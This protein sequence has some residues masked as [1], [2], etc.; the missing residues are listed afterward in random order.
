MYTHKQCI[1]LYLTNDSNFLV[2]I[3]ISWQISSY[4]STLF[5]LQPEI[6]IWTYSF[7]PFMNT[8]F[9]ILFLFWFHCVLVLLFWWETHGNAETQTNLVLNG[10]FFCVSLKFLGEPFIFQTTVKTYYNLCFNLVKFHQCLKILLTC[11]LRGGGSP[12]Q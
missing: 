6:N 4:Y 8:H 12:V 3:W 2:Q 5:Y 1:A 7:T 10:F 11:D 9:S